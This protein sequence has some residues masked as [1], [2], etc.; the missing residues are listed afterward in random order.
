MEKLFTDEIKKRDK[1]DWEKE[2]IKFVQKFEPPKGKRE[3]Y[4][5]PYF[6]GNISLCQVYLNA[7]KKKK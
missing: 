3:V 4:L 1:K 7:L 6:S 2:L 5:F